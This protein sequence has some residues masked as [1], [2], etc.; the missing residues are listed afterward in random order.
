MNK[1][2]IELIASVCFD[3]Y[4][5]VNEQYGI[6]EQQGKLYLFNIGKKTVEYEICSYDKYKK[7]Y[8]QI[9]SITYLVNS[10]KSKETL[11]VT[12]HWDKII[13]GKCGDIHIIGDKYIIIEGDWNYSKIIDYSYVELCILE[14]ESGNEVYSGGLISMVQ[15]TKGKKEVT[16]MD[17]SN[18]HSKYCK[19]RVTYIKDNKIVTNIVE[20]NMMAENNFKQ[21]LEINRYFGLMGVK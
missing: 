12:P 13:R 18:P 17:L 3:N 8:Y 21:S 16:W 20:N 11:V 9:Q 6:V 5:E 2:D 15:T 7:G 14:K 4:I 1:R 19:K 10:T